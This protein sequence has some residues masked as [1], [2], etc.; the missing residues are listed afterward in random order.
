MT[1]ESQLLEIIEQQQQQLKEQQKQQEQALQQLQEQQKALKAQAQAIEE[2]EAYT[3]T[4][5]ARHSE[6][7]QIVKRYRQ[8]VQQLSEQTNSQNFSQDLQTQLAS[9]LKAHVM[10]SLASLDLRELTKASLLELLPMLTQADLETQ[11]QALAQRLEAK[12]DSVSSYHEHLRDLA[13][14]LSERLP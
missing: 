12:L 2:L 1:L 8:I 6:A 13:Q 11:T 3:A 7:G 10:K 4:L 9:D 14:S 5:R